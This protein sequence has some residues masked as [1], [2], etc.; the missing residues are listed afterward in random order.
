MRSE[1]EIIERM[2]DVEERMSSPTIGIAAK[3]QLQKEKWLLFWVLEKR[4][5]KKPNTDDLLKDILFEL[6]KIT[7]KA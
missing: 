6:R 5:D 2:Q 1:R 3:K 4:D 7:P